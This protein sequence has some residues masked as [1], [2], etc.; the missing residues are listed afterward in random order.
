MWSRFVAW[1][2]RTILEE[3]AEWLALPPERDASRYWP[4]HTGEHPTAPTELE[5]PPPGTTDLDGRT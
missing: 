3:D 5:L 2:R 4:P 1:V